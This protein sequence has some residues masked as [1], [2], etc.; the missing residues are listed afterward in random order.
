MITLRLPPTFEDASDGLKI[1]YLKR[2]LQEGVE[3]L[4]VGE[5]C[6]GFDFS[7]GGCPGHEIESEAE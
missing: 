3:C 4:P 1:A 5:P 6:E 2:Q 7:G